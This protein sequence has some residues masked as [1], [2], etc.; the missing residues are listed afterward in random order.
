MSWRSL[1]ALAAATAVAVMASNAG[2]AERIPYDPDTCSTD[3]GGKVFVRL[4][5]GLSFA[6]PAWDLVGLHGAPPRPKDI[7]LIADPDE[8]EGCPLHPIIAQTIAV[9]YRPVAEPHPAEP[10]DQRWHPSRLQIFSFS[11]PVGMQDKYLET[12]TRQCIDRLNAEER[13]DILVDHQTVQECRLDQRGHEDSLDWP[14]YFV[15]R[16]GAHPELSGR[17][18]TVRCRG[19]IIAP[20]RPRICE[21]AYSVEGGPSVFYEFSDGIVPR[22]HITDFDL[23]IRAFIEASRVPEYDVILDR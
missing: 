14:S 9:A 15:A 4:F 23:Q 19:T 7:G 18:F 8:P 6:F 17:R 12:F 3:A 1:R 10:E 22:E 11:G 21:V 5:T 20:G 16:P 2:S 13:E